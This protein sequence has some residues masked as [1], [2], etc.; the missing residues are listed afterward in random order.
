MAHLGQGQNHE[1]PPTASIHDHGH[2]LGVDGAEVAVPGHLGDADVIV[3]L[4]G[5]HRL[6]ED[7]AELAGPHD[8]PGHGELIGGG[9]RSRCSSGSNIKAKQRFC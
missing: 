9:K 3:A 8:L 2:E 6:A 1:G 5:L 4:V 7:V